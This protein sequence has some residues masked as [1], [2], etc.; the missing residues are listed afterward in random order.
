MLYLNRTQ[1]ELSKDIWKNIFMSETYFKLIYLKKN[2]SFVTSVKVCL[3]TK[4]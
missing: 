3:M 2:G 4:K 1:I